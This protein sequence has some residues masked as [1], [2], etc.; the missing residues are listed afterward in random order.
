[1]IKNPSDIDKISVCDHYLEF[2]ERGKRYEKVSN[3]FRKLLYESE[4]DIG[5]ER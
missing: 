3:F 4:T 5:I 1:M 2:L